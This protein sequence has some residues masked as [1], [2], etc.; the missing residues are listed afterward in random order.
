MRE[1]LVE[2]FR[3]C[4]EELGY[5]FHAGEKRRMAGEMRE[6]PAVWLMPLEI[7]AVEGHRDCRV[8][9]RA[10]MKL[11]TLSGFAKTSHEALWQMLER[12]ALGMYHA[13]AESGHVHRVGNF[14]SSP[15]ASYTTKNGD[16]SIGASFDVEMFYCI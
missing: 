14:R 12:D 2:E 5:T 13:L 8:T 1:V 6:F 16:V 11:V 4:A 3:K 10:E 15:S 7:I 9:Y